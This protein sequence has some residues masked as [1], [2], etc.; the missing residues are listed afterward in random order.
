MFLLARAQSRAPDQ[1]G[2]AL[3]LARASEDAG[4]YGDA[5]LAYDRY[6]ALA[7][8]E[9]ARAGTGPARWR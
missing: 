5:V 2:I 8:N 9:A 3:A 7:P 4:Y 6:L 1:P